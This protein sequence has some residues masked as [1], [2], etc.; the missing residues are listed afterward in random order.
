M[1]MQVEDV[2]FSTYD[3]CTKPDLEGPYKNKPF[4][5]QVRVLPGCCCVK[6]SATQLK[7]L[8]AGVAVL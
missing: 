8:V 2:L 3:A 6:H 1:H 4:K 7:T 5:A